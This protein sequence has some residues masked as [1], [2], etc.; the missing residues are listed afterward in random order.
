MSPTTQDFTLLHDETRMHTRYKQDQGQ[1][2]E[3]LVLQ[4]MTKKANSPNKL[5][6]RFANDLLN[7]CH[8]LGT[9]KHWGD[10]YE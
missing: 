2:W 1:A 8:V 4:L 10:K 9:A 3:R 7:V 6:I 5:S